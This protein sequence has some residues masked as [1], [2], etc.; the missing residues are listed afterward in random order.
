MKK[1][2]PP[3]VHTFPAPAVLFACGTVAEPNLITCSWFGTVCSEPPHV[4]VSVRKSRFSY[5]LIHDNFEF[6]AN[7]MKIDRLEAIKLCG[8]KSGRDTDKFKELGL[9]AAP[10]PPLESAP[11]I[12]EAPISLAC[13]V[14]HELEL[15]THQI[16]IAEVVGMF[17][18]EELIRPSG[19]ANPFSTEQI[20]YLDGKYW[21]LVK[22]E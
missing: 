5:R 14:K 15:G 22:G 17:V 11:M 9:T 13:K 1:S 8:T 12:A 21:K 2:L 19:R 7:I 3:Y 10:C 4:S 16:F 18:E 6:T 20:V